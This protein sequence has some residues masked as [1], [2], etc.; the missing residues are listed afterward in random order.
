MPSH[1]SRR[2]YNVV[3]FPTI[4][5]E[6]LEAINGYF[7]EAPLLKRYPPGYFELFS[8]WMRQHTR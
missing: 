6:Q 5:H 4:A 2:F 7:D 3:I 8:N 1:A